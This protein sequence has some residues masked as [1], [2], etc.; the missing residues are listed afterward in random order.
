MT[1]VGREDETEEFLF[2]VGE[3]FDHVASVVGVEEELKT[4]RER[5]QRCVSIVERERVSSEQEKQYK[6]HPTENYNSI[7]NSPGH[8]WHY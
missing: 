8:S 1:V 5:E 7:S 3:G 6:Q 2:R 4:W